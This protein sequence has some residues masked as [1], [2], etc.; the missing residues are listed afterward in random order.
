[1]LAAR[2]KVILPEIIS[3]TQSAFVPG[4]L[5]TDN[6]LVAYECIHKIKNKRKGKYGLCAVKLDMH[7]AYDRVEWDFLKKMMGRLGFHSHWIDLVMACVTSVSYSVRFNSQMTEGFT[8]TRGIRQGDPLSPYLF[9]LCAEGLS[10]CLLHAEE[11]GGIEGI[12]VCRNAP[13]VSHLLFADDSLILLK[14]DLNNATSLQQVLETYC[15]NSGQLVSVAKSSIFFSPNTNV[16][17]KVEICNI[18]NINTEALSDKYLGL[19]ALVG[20]DRS[21]IL[22]LWRLIEGRAKS[23]VFLHVAKLSCRNPDF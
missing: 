11:V 8:P 21:E 23:G 19:P 9:L 14:A 3:P 18:L 16:D 13:S 1:M 5:I 4:R 12:K 6:V 20:A 2:L 7:K 10:S 15:A 17:E 22:P